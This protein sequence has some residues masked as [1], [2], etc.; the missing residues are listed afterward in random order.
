MDSFLPFFDDLRFLAAAASAVTGG[1]QD[2][3]GDKAWHAV[4][5][6]SRLKLGACEVVIHLHVVLAESHIGGD[7]PVALLPGTGKIFDVLK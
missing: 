2:L 4:T 5:F 1:F 3:S 7:Q 6:S